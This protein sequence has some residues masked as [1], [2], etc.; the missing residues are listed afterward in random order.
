[1]FNEILSEESESGT[2]VSSLYDLYETESGTNVSP[3]YDLST[4]FS[5]LTWKCRNKEETCHFKLFFECKN[6]LYI[7]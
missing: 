2:K 6:D 7:F 1:M 4:K 3:L 5:F